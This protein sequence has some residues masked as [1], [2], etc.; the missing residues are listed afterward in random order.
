MSVNCWK[1]K[2]DFEINAAVTDILN[3]IDCESSEFD[4][5]FASLRL[6]DLDDGKFNPCNN[7]SDAWP[8]IIDNKISLM[9]DGDT[10]EASI[11]FDGELLVHGTDETLSEYYEDKNPLRAAMIVYLEI[12]GVKP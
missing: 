11:D 10:W 1:D 8:I 9:N 5:F 6:L 7:P 12:K 4:R 3:N 2:T